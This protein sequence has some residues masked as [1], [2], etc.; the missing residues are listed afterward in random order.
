[1]ASD[2]STTAFLLMTW[3]IRSGLLRPPFRFRLR[4]CRGSSGG[5][6]SAD[7]ITDTGAGRIMGR[8]SWIRGIRE[9]I[10]GAV[11]MPVAVWGTCAGVKRDEGSW[12]VGNG[13]RS[14]EAVE[15]LQRCAVIR[16][17]ES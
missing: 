4:C 6:I 12:G 11:E 10:M 9:A 16:L 2:L 7:L 5:R 1:M 3:A 13:W 15:G 8:S 14:M 17:L